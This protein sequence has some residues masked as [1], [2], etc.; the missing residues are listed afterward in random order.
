MDWYGILQVEQAA[1]DAIIRKRYQKLALLLHPNKNKFVGA[2]AAFK[3]IGEA[4]RILSDQ[5]K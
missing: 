5:G 2:E 1:D 3:L 4:N